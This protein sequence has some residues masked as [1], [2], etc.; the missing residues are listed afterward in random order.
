MAWTDDL[1]EKI[2][3]FSTKDPDK[4]DAD[5]IRKDPRYAS[6]LEKLEDLY[7]KR[8]VM[9][10]Q[11]QKIELDIDACLLLVAMNEKKEEITKSVKNVSSRVNE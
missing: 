3:N 6:V 10:A 11:L 8:N 2:N 5:R 4:K 1:K 9:N 7:D